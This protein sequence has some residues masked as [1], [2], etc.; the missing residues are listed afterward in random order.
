MMMCPGTFTPL[1]AFAV[2]VTVRSTPSFV[3]GAPPSYPP[4]RSLRRVELFLGD[5][6]SNGT[7]FYGHPVGKLPVFRIPRGWGIKVCG[8]NDAVDLVMRAPGWQRWARPW[9]PFSAW[10]PSSRPLE[11]VL[12]SMTVDEGNLSTGGLDAFGEDCIAE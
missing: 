6:L 12:R 4:F 5:F 9:S 11:I 3:I 8:A 1:T 7:N 2:G 10:M